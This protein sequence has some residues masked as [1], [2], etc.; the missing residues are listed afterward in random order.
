MV[1]FA[2]TQDQAKTNNFRRSVSLAHRAPINNVCAAE[3]D[4][5]FPLHRQEDYIQQR[6]LETWRL[7]SACEAAHSGHRSG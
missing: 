6:E 5:L 7:L 3:D 4:I 2:V 1:E